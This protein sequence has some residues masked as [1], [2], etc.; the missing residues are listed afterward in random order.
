MKLKRLFCVFI[1]MISLLSGCAGPDIEPEPVT[2]DESGALEVGTVLTV[3]NTDERLKLLDNKTA[4]AADG[5]YYA[6]WGI[7]DSEP[8]ENSDGE[9][10][11][12]YD[13]QLY[14][15]LSETKD[16][17]EAQKSMDTWL[18]AART[19]YNVSA[20]EEITGGGQTYTMLTYTCKS[21]DTPY[22]R[23]VSAFAVSDDSAV[24]IELTCVEGFQEDLRNILTD[25]LDCCSYSTN[26]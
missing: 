11:D 8:Y 25:F 1:I 6:T 12:L 14:L 7:G 19:N 16:Q 18:D 13:A 21:P 15:L 9:T 10:V 26:K 3:R 20:E 22:A 23:G 24:C 17:E 2:V 5:L 4:L